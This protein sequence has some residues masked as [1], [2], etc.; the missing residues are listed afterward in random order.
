M[1]PPDGAG[2]PGGAWVAE[3]G[4]PGK[5]PP[6]AWLVGKTKHQQS[7][8]AVALKNVPGIRRQTDPDTDDREGGLGLQSWPEGT[9]GPWRGG[10]PSA[11]PSLPNPGAG[12]PRNSGSRRGQR[13][14][15]SQTSRSIAKPRCPQQEDDMDGIHIVAF[16]EEADPGEGR[17]LVAGVV[18]GH[19]GAWEM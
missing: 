12:V 7:L 16:A 3:D 2:S 8:E 1:S 6:R 19:R 18:E 14:R 15:G 4:S 17:T 13:A 10:E 9:R 11:S 5:F